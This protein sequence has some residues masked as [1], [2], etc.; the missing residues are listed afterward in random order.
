MLIVANYFFTCP[1]CKITG[2]LPG[3]LA[4]EVDSQLLAKVIDA[5]KAAELLGDIIKRFPVPS[6]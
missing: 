2:N 5:V 4:A 3:V 6:R 1:L